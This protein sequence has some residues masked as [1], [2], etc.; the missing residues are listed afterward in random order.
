MQVSLNQVA[1]SLGCH[2]RTVLRAITGQGNPNWSESMDPKYTV[3]Q[4]A[5]AF[6]CNAELLEAI[7]HGTDKLLTPALAAKRLNCTERTL[8]NRSMPPLIRHGGIIRYSQT[9]LDL[10]EAGVF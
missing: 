8:R 4:I 7:F 6:G 1:A 10:I 3:R 5:K 2:Q 9:T